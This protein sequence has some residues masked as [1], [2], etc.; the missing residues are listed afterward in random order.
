MTHLP[1]AATTH[2]L[3]FHQLT[4]RDFER[5]CLWL[6]E[7]E[8]WERAEHP[9]TAGS[10]D[11]CNLT[12]W[13]QGAL[14]A[15][16]C[17]QAQHLDPGDALRV[18][19]KVLALPP[20]ERPVGLI[21]L[22]TC[23]ISADTLQRAQDRCAGQIECYFRTDTELDHRVRRHPDIVEEFF[24]P[25]SPFSP[26]IIS[27]EQLLGFAS[28]ILWP[29]EGLNRP[30]GELLAEGSTQSRD[31]G[32]AVSNAPDPIVRWA[33]AVRLKALPLQGVSMSVE[34]ARQVVWP[35]KRLDRPMGELLPENAI[36]LQD[37]AYAIA[38]AYDPQVRAA[39][40]VL[41]AEIVRR[42]EVPDE[43]AAFTTEAVFPPTEKTLRVI[44]GSTFLRDQ[45]EQ[46]RSQGWNLA[47]VLFVLIAVAAFAVAMPTASMGPAIALVIAVLLLLGSVGRL[48]AGQRN[49]AQGRKGEEEM[50]SFLEGHLNGK[51]YLF[52]NV[53]LPDEKGD[54]DGVLIGSKGIY[55]LEVKA[56]TGYNRNV[57]S[58]WQRRLRGHWRTLDR[59]PTRQARRN[60]ARLGTYLKEH[61]V[62]AWVEPRVVWAGSGKLWLERPTVPVWQ[63]SNLTHL[64]ED[65]ERGRKLR[66]VVITRTVA[67][68]EDMQTKPQVSDH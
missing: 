38:N 44:E 51:W 26:I 41:G 20:G 64:L 42:T 4:P 34:E 24:G 23:E 13:R 22:V 46:S 35:F 5:L 40:A 43:T 55:A 18:I 1:I 67:A 19:D 2:P 3:P 57:G 17:K 66:R 16:R 54:I 62:E 33:A 39:A 63:L 61:G 10:E 56:Y 28:A 15:F 50:V 47:L 52:R 53:V 6:V 31:L 25:P 8:G 29:S 37:L 48:R 58:R 9:G 12:A 11:G 45:E 59:N 36:T 30:L 7:R 27:G 32:W 49:F 68:L 65:I 14:W 60:A 21:F